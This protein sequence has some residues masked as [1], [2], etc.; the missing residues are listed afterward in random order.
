MSEEIILFYP[1]EPIVIDFENTYKK[2]LEINLYNK[3]NKTVLYKIFA[4]I[5]IFSK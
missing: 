2:E 1:P 4:I 3:T 5:K